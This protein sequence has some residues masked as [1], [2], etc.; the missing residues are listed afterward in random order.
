M[1]KVNV[2]R[3]VTAYR[4]IGKAKLTKMEDPEKFAMFK[5]MRSMKKT[6]SEFEEFLNDAS[7]RL[8]PEGFDAVA[9]KI[10]RKEELSE[11]ENEM[12]GKYNKDVTACVEDELKK[13]I[14]L[15]E[16]FS[17]DALDRFFASNDF[18]L[19]E[20]VFLSEFFGDGE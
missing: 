4:M 6:A 17:E 18:T 15:C 8:R 3:T 10:Q 7:E 9:E 11:D 12:A 19:G 1:K 2:D 20:T 5:V 13:E 16:P 14:D